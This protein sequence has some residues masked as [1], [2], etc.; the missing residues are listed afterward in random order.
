MTTGMIMA[1][2]LGGTVVEILAEAGD[3]H[4]VLAERRADRRRGRGLAGR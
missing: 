3:V 1:D 2:L 4:A